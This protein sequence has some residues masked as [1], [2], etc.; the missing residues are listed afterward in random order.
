MYERGAH[1]QGGIGEIAME[2]YGY[3]SICGMELGTVGSCPNQ[4][5]GLHDPPK[6]KK[7]HKCPVC[8][9]AGKVSRPPNVVGD[10][11]TWS[12]SSCVISYE[13]N[14]CKGTGIVWEPE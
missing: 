3:C 1:D 10:A 4:Y 7:P 6:S 9:G 2:M 13:C 11:P 12:T 8:N 5:D 14:A